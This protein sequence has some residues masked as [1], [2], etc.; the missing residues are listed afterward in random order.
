M[1]RTS[2]WRLQRAESHCGKN[3]VLGSS[4][5]MRNGLLPLKCWALLN[6]G[7]QNCGKD[8]MDR[9][10]EC[11]PELLGG[12]N[13]SIL[14]KMMAQGLPGD[15]V[16][17]LCIWKLRMQSEPALEQAH[18]QGCAVS[19]AGLK[20]AGA[21]LGEGTFIALTLCHTPASQPHGAIQ[22]CTSDFSGTNPSSQCNA[23][24]AM[25]GG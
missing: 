23:H 16:E 15:T 11:C 10:H 24:Q 21:Q 19:I 8:K 17:H 12:K 3:N 4:L 2:L 14:T 20:Q 1:K 18:R 6:N 9:T 5:V 13:V 25:N 7:L 22:V